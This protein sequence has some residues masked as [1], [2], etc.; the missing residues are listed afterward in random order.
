MS[1]NAFQKLELAEAKELLERLNKSWRG[2]AF[3]TQRTIVHAKSLS[4]MDKWVLAEAI[5]AANVPEK[6]CAFI[7]NGNEC[8]PIE[9]NADFVPEMIKKNGIVLGRDSAPDYL[10]FWFEYARIGSDRLVL[11]EAIDDMP[12]REDPT[13]QARKSLAKSVTPMTL[14][15]TQPTICTFKACILFRD[16]LFNCTID[17]HANGQVRIKNREALAEGL[18]VSDPLTGF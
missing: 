3:D 12:W 1:A 17:V 14:I 18:T 4:F 9:F 15:D 8:V 11:V 6:K 7:D 10:R 5:D 13:P 2:S 16:T